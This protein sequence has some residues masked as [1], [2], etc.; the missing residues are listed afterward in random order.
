MSDESLGIGNW[1]LGK[2]AM[3]DVLHFLFFCFFCFSPARRGGGGRDWRRARPGTRN[4]E[5]PEGAR[6]SQ[7]Q[8]V[9]NST[10]WRIENRQQLIANR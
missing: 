1:E 6:K 10:E 4:K 7:G 5:E 8:G 9:S 2:R 3:G